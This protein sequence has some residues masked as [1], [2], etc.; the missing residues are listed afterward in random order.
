[1]NNFQRRPIID[2]VLDYTDKL[3]K[4]VYDEGCKSAYK[5]YEIDDQGRHAFTTA[6]KFKAKSFGWGG[7]DS[8]ILDV[9]TGDT[10]EHGNPVLKFLLE[11]DGE[12]TLPD[13]K[14]WVESWIGRD[15]R[16]SQDDAML[17]SCILN[18]LSS[19]GT[20]KVYNRSNDFM[21]GNNE[22][23]TLLLKVVLEESGLQ[24]NATV[25]KAKSDL[26]NL[27]ETMV[28]LGHNVSKFNDH[29]L[30]IM[31]TLT[32]NGSSAPDLIHQLFPAYLVC[33]DKEFTGYIKDKKNAFEEGQA[34]SEK[35]LMK[36]AHYKF[37]TLVDSNQ[38]EA[39]DAQQEEIMALKC[40]LKNVKSQLNNRSKRKR[41]GKG[42]GKNEGNGN[43]KKKK[44]NPPEWM[45][46]PPSKEGPYSKKVNGKLYHFCCNENGAPSNAGC[47]K[48]VRHKPSECKGDTFKWTPGKP[49]PVTIPGFKAKTK[50]QRELQVKAA[51]LGLTNVSI[52]D[53][54]LDDVELK[55]EEESDENIYD[56]ETDEE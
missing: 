6:L 51:T 8:G 52:S 9:P 4:A 16:A 41:N 23:G 11:H 19:E 55:E 10:D 37:K 18:G 22:S 43:S 20:I 44:K 53:E 56:A 14:T 36:F 50:K 34:L 40:E 31:A 54:A 5:G 46:I 39:P 25:M 29:V 12:F 21:V 24:T 45:T 26:A 3:H 7:D 13:I 32:R 1:M 49:N 33:P 30:A 48:W 2:G 38:W 28:K 35:E 47:N 17:F 27:S 42:N 15:N